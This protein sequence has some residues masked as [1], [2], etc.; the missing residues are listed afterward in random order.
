M[1]VMTREEAVVVFE[2]SLGPGVFVHVAGIP[3][4]IIHCEGKDDL[5]LFDRDTSSRLLLLLRHA[6]IR[7]AQGETDI[8]LDFADES[9]V[10]TDAG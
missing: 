9:L 5:T 7:M 3:A 4:E 10:F 6:R 8:H 2:K 1:Q